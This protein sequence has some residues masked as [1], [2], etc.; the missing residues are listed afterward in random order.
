MRFVFNNVY[1]F[2]MISPTM[3]VFFKNKNGNICLLLFPYLRIYQLFF[4]SLISTIPKKLPSLISAPRSETSCYVRDFYSLKQNADA[5]NQASAFCC[6]L[7]IH[8]TEML[9]STR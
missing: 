6:Y 4:S 7:Y 1:K 5:S 3:Q 2:I 8:G 9:L